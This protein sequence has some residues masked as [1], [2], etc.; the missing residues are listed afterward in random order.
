MCEA[1]HVEAM[2]HE[3]CHAEESPHGDRTLATPEGGQGE[4]ENRKHRAEK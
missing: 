3:A 2:E 1:P 4:E